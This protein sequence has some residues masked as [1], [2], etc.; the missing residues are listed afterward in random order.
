MSNKKLHMPLTAGELSMRLHELLRDKEQIQDELQ[1]Y[2]DSIDSVD[3][4][5]DIE[6]AMDYLDHFHMLMTSLYIIEKQL[7]E[8]QFPAASNYNN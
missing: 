6:D 8:I 5:D 3:F 2:I 1:N 7:A 4:F